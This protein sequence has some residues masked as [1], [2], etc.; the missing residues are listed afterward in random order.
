MILPSLVTRT[1]HL[2]SASVFQV[3]AGTANEDHF[4][5]V[6]V[7]KQSQQNTL[8]FCTLYAVRTHHGAVLLSLLA[9]VLHK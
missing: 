2:N 8:P 7:L 6:E 1:L 3:L 9:A 5:C 4:E